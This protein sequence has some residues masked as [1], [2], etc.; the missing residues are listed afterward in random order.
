MKVVSIA[1]IVASAIM[2]MLRILNKLLANPG[3]FIFVMVLVFLIQAPILL[4][5]FIDWLLGN[6]PNDTDA[7]S[8]D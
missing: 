2:P 4:P 1:A 7:E 6:K 8:R 5:N 3:M